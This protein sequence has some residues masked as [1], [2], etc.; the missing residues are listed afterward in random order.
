M[1][2]ED[3]DE[4]Y[5]EDYE[6]YDDEGGD[7]DLEEVG[8]EAED[9]QTEAP[10][11]QGLRLLHPLSAENEA[12]QGLRLLQPL[13]SGRADISAELTHNSAFG[14][15]LAYTLEDRMASQMRSTAYGERDQGQ[16][17]EDVVV[18]WKL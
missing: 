13:C 10:V 1:G 17:G 14:D 3:E 4:Y 9:G 15:S 6:E 7:E 18:E 11:P 8:D 16:P 12:P 5:A 2:Q